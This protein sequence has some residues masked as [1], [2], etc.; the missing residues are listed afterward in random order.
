MGMLVCWYVGMLVCED[1]G[2]WEDA[3]MNGCWYV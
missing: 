3:R 1:A 2:V